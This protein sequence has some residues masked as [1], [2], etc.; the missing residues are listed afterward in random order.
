[1]KYTIIIL[2]IIFATS[3][4]KEAK[5]PL[6]EKEFTKLLIDVHL[7]DAVLGVEGYRNVRGKEEYQK[8]YNYLFN[9][10][11]VS[12]EVFDSC[13]VFYSKNLAN[14]EKIYQVVVDSLNRLKSRYDKDLSYKLKRDT[15][16]LWNLKKEYSFPADSA[17]MIEAQV[18][19]SEV[20]MYNL[21]LKIKLLEGDKGENNRITGFF[22]KK[23]KMGKDSI[24]PFDTIKIYSDTVWRYYKLHKFAEDTNYTNLHFKILDCD[25]LD[26]LTNRRV[27]VK[28]IKLVNP[29]FEGSFPYFEEFPRR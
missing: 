17:N 22:V 9:K 13:V 25:N 1:M 16:N 15:L 8:Y 11:G 19:F 23:T 5:A 26:S 12:P 6:G 18:P 29:L 24:I 28:S 20:G 3:C 4:G 10:H 27:E 2:A 14:Y 21:S 7:T